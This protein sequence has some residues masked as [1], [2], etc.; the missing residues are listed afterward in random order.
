[1]ASWILQCCKIMRGRRESGPTARSKNFK[2]PIFKRYWNILS[3]LYSNRSRTSP[4]F[5]FEISQQIQLLETSK[6]LAQRGHGWQ[7]D[8]AMA[9]IFLSNLHK[10]MIDNCWKFQ[11]DI[12]F[13][14]LARGKRL[15]TCCNQWTLYGHLVIVIVILP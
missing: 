10:L 9:K 11:E 7:A 6:F 12:L 5:L 1:M 2:M 13:Y 8:W 14:I 4:F 3:R 15:K